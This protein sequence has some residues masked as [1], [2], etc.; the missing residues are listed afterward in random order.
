MPA[1]VEIQCPHCAASLKLKSRDPLGK[2]VQCPKCAQPFVAKERPRTAQVIDDYEDYEPASAPRP[3]R[4]P[5][6]KDEFDEFDDFGDPG[7]FD[8]D[9]GAPPPKSAGGGRRKKSVKKKQQSSRGALKWVFVG[10]GIAGGVAVLVLGI[11]LAF[12]MFGSKKLDLAWLPE[13]ATSISMTRYG[14]LMKSQLVK[15]GLSDADERAIE[16]MKDEWGFGVADI[17]S[18]TTASSGSET[19]RVLRTTVDLDPDKIL[20]H[21]GDYEKT[22]YDGKDVYRYGNNLMYFPDKRTAISG[23]E[24]S[25]KK[26]ID[27]GPKA[28]KRE[29]LGFADTGYDIVKINLVKSNRLSGEINGIPIGKVVATC[30]GTSIS[31]SIKAKKQQRFASVE[32]AK[33][34]YD[35]V[36]E[37]QEKLR[38]KLSSEDFLRNLPEKEREEARE[39]ANS[40]SFSFS[41]SGDTIT[42]TVKLTPPKSLRKSRFGLF[43]MGRTSEVSFA[44]HNPGRF[45]GVFPNPFGDRNRF[46]NPNPLPNRPRRNIGRNRAGFNRPGFNRAPRGSVKIYDIVVNNY[47]GNRDQ[48]FEAK[49]ALQG[50]NGLDHARTEVNGN[51]ITAYSRPNQNVN[52]NDILRR[53]QQH[54]FGNVSVTQF[55]TE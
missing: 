16:K 31:S 19:L 50:V 29:E 52:N 46:R 14:N 28:K 36:Q 9:F 42:T 38:E 45:F 7:G 20:K 10:G 21:A 26:A 51:R 30:E 11:W 12:W 8:D 35:K 25:V 49:V 13:D 4:R 40:I 44:A 53:L 1:L 32:D 5:K 34:Y 15:E 24:D 54:G 27:R 23:P 55:R 18:Y 22:T 3:K 37:L 43:G 48:A 47:R 2:K 33:E 17:D 39:F 41:R 6:P